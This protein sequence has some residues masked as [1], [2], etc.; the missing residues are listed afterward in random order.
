MLPW[1]FPV[2]DG[3]FPWSGRIDTQQPLVQLKL[4]LSPEWAVVMNY[5]RAGFGFPA[6]SSI[7]PAEKHPAIY[8]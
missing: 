2:T 8:A 1:V 6:A 3:E 5:R 4:D 7:S